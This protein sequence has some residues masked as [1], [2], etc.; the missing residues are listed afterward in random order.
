MP[1]SVRVPAMP[2]AQRTGEIYRH[3]ADPVA[4]NRRANIFL[5]AGIS[6]LVVAGVVSMF[7][8]PPARWL[9]LALGVAGCATFM[10]LLY[11]R[12]KQASGYAGDDLIDLIVVPSGPITRGGFQ[13]SWRDLSAF[14]LEVLTNLG[15]QDR[16]GMHAYLDLVDGTAVKARTTTDPQRSVFAGANRI[17]ADLGTPERTEVERVREVLRQACA[18]GGVE[19]T[20]NERIAG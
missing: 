17:K 8:E 9:L 5:Y 7:L 14:R 16:V 2:P 19:F 6:E 10:L 12:T 1:E 13:L 4:N 11:P 3:V 20:Y 18:A 15:G